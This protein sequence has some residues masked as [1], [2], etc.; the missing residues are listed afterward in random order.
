M[1]SQE[2][3]V[4]LPLVV[5][6]LAR[7]DDV[8]VGDAVLVGK[9]DVVTAPTD[10]LCDAGQRVTGLGDIA[11]VTSRLY[12]ELRID[13]SLDSIRIVAGSGEP[14]AAVLTVAPGACDDLGSNSIDGLLADAGALVNFSLNLVITG[15][16]GTLALVTVTPLASLDL[17]GENRR[18]SRADVVDGVLHFSVSGTEIRLALIAIS[19]HAKK[20]V[21]DQDVQWQG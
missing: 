4:I 21:A 14:I 7:E 11:A 5:D 8:W 1:L 12:A 13:L 6:L 17:V 20:C 2:H 15:T 3:L 10:L 19:V 9:A 18:L 16:D